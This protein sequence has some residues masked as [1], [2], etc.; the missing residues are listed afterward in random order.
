MHHIIQPSFEFKLFVGI[1][2]PNSQESFFKALIRDSA[3]FGPHLGNL[4]WHPSLSGVVR[5]VL[6]I[7]HT[8]TTCP[9]RDIFTAIGRPTVQGR[10][11]NGFDLSLRDLSVKFDTPLSLMAVSP[12]MSAPFVSLSGTIRDSGKL[13]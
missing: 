6:G 13:S 11:R 2:H 10:I 3:P 5:Y 7:S 9:H 12:F 4:I 8:H 1:S